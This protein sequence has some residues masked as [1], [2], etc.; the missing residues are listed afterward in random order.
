[1]LPVRR[2]QLRARA[3]VHT[4]H[5]LNCPFCRKLPVRCSKAML[6]SILL[7]ETY[8]HPLDTGEGPGM[9]RLWCWN[10]RSLDRRSISFCLC[11]CRGRF[12]LIDFLH[13]LLYGLLEIINMVLI[14][15][16]ATTFSIIVRTSSSVGIAWG[17]RRLCSSSKARW[18]HSSLSWNWPDCQLEACTTNGTR[19]GG[20][21]PRCRT[22][23]SSPCLVHEFPCKATGFVN[24][25]GLGNLPPSDEIRP[26]AACRSCP[27]PSAWLVGKEVV[28]IEA[29]GK[30]LPMSRTLLLEVNFIRRFSMYSKAWLNLPSTLAFSETKTSEN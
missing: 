7:G 8:C 2:L 9:A 1:M 28:G 19:I 5:W 15:S 3:G 27:Y 14:R 17:G 16:L 26:E 13:I 30:R 6:R 18:H 10:S 12:D 25:V 11:G 20:S 21:W 4:D 23:W 24:A 22:C 29:K